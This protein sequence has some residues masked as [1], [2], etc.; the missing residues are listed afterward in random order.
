VPELQ[1]QFEQPTTKWLSLSTVTDVEVFVDPGC[2]WAWV[3]SRWVREVAPARDLTVFWRS[4]CLEIRDDYDV[5]PTVPAEFRQQA[6]EGH[7]I[8]HRMLRVFEAARA[9]VGEDAVDR[10][11]AEWGRRY[12]VL[13]RVR[14][15]ELLADCITAVGLEDRLLKAANDESWDVPIREAMEV[16]YAYGGPKTQTPA[17]VVRSDPPHGFKGPVMAPAPTGPSALQ[18]WD[19]VQ[20]LSEHEGFFEIT[21][22]RAASP[23]DHMPD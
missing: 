19:A 20:V 4:F 18:L 9:E 12:F 2:P 17:I 10:L 6:L 13:K 8:S 3:T 22:P 16:A 11:Y 5:A 14:T 1:L 7:A 21:R 15:K 23:H